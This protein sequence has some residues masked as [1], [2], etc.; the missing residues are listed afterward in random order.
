MW[1]LLCFVMSEKANNKPSKPYDIRERLF[2]F[3]SDVTET[4][5]KIHTLNRTLSELSA[6]LVKAAVSAAANAEEADDGSSRRDF[7]AKKRI[8]LRELK[9]SRLRLRVLRRA[10]ILDESADALIQESHELVCI[11]ATIIRNAD[12]NRS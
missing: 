8:C 2:L 1:Q 3:A 11:V 6:Q 5:Q 10:H 7:L 12:R 4:L 9:E